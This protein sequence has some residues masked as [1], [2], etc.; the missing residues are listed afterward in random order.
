[1]SAVAEIA[2]VRWGYTMDDIDRLCR[3]VFNKTRRTYL[4]DH[5]DHLSAAWFGITECLFDSIVRPT[6]ADLIAAGIQRVASESA[7]S[8]QFYGINPSAPESQ[9]PRFAV[10]WRREGHD[11]FT[12]VIAERESLPRV[13]SVL[14]DDLYEAIVTLAAYGNMAEAAKAIGMEYRPYYKRV[15]RARA[16]LIEAW[17]APEHPA[18]LG[19]GFGDTCRS[20][21]SRAE[22]SR[23]NEAGL[24]ICRICARNAERRW[25]A[26]QQRGGAVTLAT[27]DDRTTA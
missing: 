21:H 14:N 24:N 22:H 11:D 18:N 8:R 7:A 15:A 3:R 1:M 25:A 4:F 17:F 23:R 20:G 19:N 2:E 13:L 6:E 10:F 16:K 26:R 9:G 12:D 27:G 5:V